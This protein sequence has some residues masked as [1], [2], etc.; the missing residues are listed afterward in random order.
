MAVVAVGSIVLRRKQLFENESTDE[1][2]HL[3]GS[4]S[5]CYGIGKQPPHKPRY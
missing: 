2:S 3:S 5:Y 4:L 1:Y